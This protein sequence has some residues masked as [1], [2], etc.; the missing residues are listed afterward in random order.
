[1]KHSMWRQ[2]GWAAI[3]APAL[4]LLAGC[5]GPYLLENNVQSF[6][7]LPAPPAQ[8]TYRFER[9]LSQQ[10]PAQVELENLADPALHKAGLRRDDSSPHYSVQLSAR[11]QEVLSP[12]ASFDDNWGWGPHRHGFRHSRL[13]GGLE[14]PWFQREVTIIVRELPS[15]RTVFE[16]RA[17]NDGP[18]L[19]G[20]AVFSAMFD[21]ALQGFPNPPS[22]PRKVNVQV[23]S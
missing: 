13:W 1:M 23:G 3:A 12:W 22:G 5:A 10:V 16:S 2:L 9:L 7:S 18:S 14:S 8:P 15:N 17:I 11:M 6:S 4:A 21:A 19:D 20:K